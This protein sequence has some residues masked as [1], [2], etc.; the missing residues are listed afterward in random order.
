MSG[1]HLIRESATIDE[2]VL[3]VQEALNQQYFYNKGSTPYIESLLAIDY[4]E[5]KKLIDLKNKYLKKEHSISYN[6]WYAGSK[7]RVYTNDE[8][9]I[10]RAAKMEFTDFEAAEAFAPNTPDVMEF[11]NTPAH[12]YRV[13]LKDKSSPPEFKA[14]LKSFF[15]QYPDY[16]PCA[17]LKLWTNSNSTGWYYVRSHNNH[18][19]DFDSE[20]MFTLLILYLGD[21][22]IRKHY[23]LQKRA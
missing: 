10:G 8:K 17:A 20:E 12:Q 5:V 22:Y 16:Y 1:A 15:A 3:R 6:G 4:S 21:S 7:V 2:Y 13:Y 11:K 19:I 14:S 9:F 23:R 18:F